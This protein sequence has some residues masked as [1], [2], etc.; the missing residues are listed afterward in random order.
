DNLP[1]WASWG[2]TRVAVAAPGVDVLTTRIGGGYGTISGTS[3][4]V[5]FVS[6]VA[7]LVYS[8]LPGIQGGLIYAAIV[9]GARAVSGLDGK[10]S[11]SGVVNAE[12]ALESATTMAPNLLPGGNSS[13]AGGGVTGTGTGTGDGSQS[14]SGSGQ[15]TPTGP[16]G[17]GEGDP[18][19][20]NLDAART[21][22]ATDPHVPG[23]IHAN[24]I[25]EMDGTCDDGGGG[26]GGGGLGDQPPVSVPGGPYTGGVSQ[27]VSFNGSN[28]E[29]AESLKRGASLD[30]GIS[31]DDAKPLV[32][33]VSEVLGMEIQKTLDFFRSTVGPDAD[34]IDRMLLSGGSAKVPGLPAYLSERFGIPVELFDSFRNVQFTNKR[35]DRDFLQEMSPNMAV[36][37]GLA[38]RGSEV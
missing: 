30:N 28:S 7:G 10:V 17:S 29:E 4:A 32:H 33:S 11:S 25:I 6:G 34:H 15:T 22:P 12:G 35:F 8:Y 13:P 27:T 24:C 18:T 16:V 2:P 26:G 37:V 14:G 21:A 20:P 38:L 3:A 36:A 31:P 19:L 23:R 5:P 1:S 9:K